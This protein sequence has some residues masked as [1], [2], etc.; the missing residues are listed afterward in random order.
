MSIW[1][2]P[3]ARLLQES[4]LFSEVQRCGGK[5]RAFIHENLFLDIHYDPA[6][7]SY[8]YALIDLA[9]TYPGDKRIFGWDD[10]PHPGIPELQMLE[11]A[12]HHFQQRLEDGQWEFRAS[13]FRG[14]I[15]DEIP[16]VLEVL[17]G[18]LAGKK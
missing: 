12:P 6:S 15:Q 18:F 9:S 2:A 8:S 11:S 5:V 14:N 1:H 4:G 16:R 3:I 10:Y 13:D 17:K 7:H